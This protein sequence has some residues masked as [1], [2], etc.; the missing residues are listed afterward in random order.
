ME[1]AVDNQSG[2]GWKTI[3]VTPT[4]LTAGTYWLALSFSANTQ[5]YY[6]ESTGGNTRHKLHPAVAN[7]FISV[8]PGSTTPYPYKVSIYGTYTPTP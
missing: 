8:W 6:Y 7:G 3:A 4:P 2:T 1:S 5:D